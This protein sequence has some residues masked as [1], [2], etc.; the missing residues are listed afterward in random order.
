MRQAELSFS[1][2]F[3]IIIIGLAV[4]WNALYCTALSG[5]DSEIINYH[6]QTGKIFFESPAS[7][8]D[9]AVCKLT[10]GEEFT[11]MGFHGI[12]IFL[13]LFVCIMVFYFLKMFFEPEASFYG[14]LLF[15][16][17]PVHTENVT[18]IS[19]KSHIIIALCF[20][21]VFLLFC[22]RHYV[23]AWILFAAGVWPGMGKINIVNLWLGVTPV[24]LVIYLLVYRKF[25]ELYRVV[26]Y[27]LIFA[28]LM[29]FHL[30]TIRERIAFT[31][32]G[33]RNGINLW[34]EFIYSTF[35][36]FWLMIY[37]AK[38]VIY[39]EGVLV[40]FNALI[41]GSAIII[42]LGGLL[43]YIYKKS[44]PLFLGLVL[45]FLFLAP[46]YSPF[47]IGWV[48]AE[49]YAYLPS[50]LLSIIVACLISTRHK[51]AVLLICMSL[52][53]FYGARTVDRNADYKTDAVFRRA[54][55]A[56]APYS[57]KARNDMGVIY[58][59][60]SNVIM[61]LQEFSNALRIKPDFKDA[62]TNLELVEKALLQKIKIKY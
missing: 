8:L 36:H 43:V 26:P 13:H 28:F 38:L 50:I 27:F 16:I 47:P 17:L 6:Y 53:F 49:R 55:L 4:Y 51:Q 46:T 19:G 56:S 60:E 2:I 24:F 39:H 9:N 25:R 54:T 5:D 7:F 61:A 23:W 15:T 42:L 32:P 30:N 20:L 33:Y 62:R 22:R 57:P 35:S 45:Y 18:W 11:P 14:A 40:N 1:Y 37:P 3:T 58:A 34:T 12:N 59:R 48:I 31:A 10:T 21:G 52:M 41:W 29:M 44:K